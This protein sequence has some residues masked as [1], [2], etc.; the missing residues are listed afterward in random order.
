VS[1]LLTQ[2]LHEQAHGPA[3]GVEPVTA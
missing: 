1:Q 2:F 3:R